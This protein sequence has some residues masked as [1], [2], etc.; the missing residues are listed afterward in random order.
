MSRIGGQHLHVDRRAL[1]RLDVTGPIDQ[2]LEQLVEFEAGYRFVREHYP[3][4]YRYLLGDFAPYIYRTDDFGKTWKPL[5]EP[6][7]AKGVRGYAHV[8]KEDTVDAR[9]LFLGT[10]FGLWVSVDGGMHW[11]QFKGGHMPAVAVRDLAIHPRDHD[12]V[13]ATHGRG[14]WI[15]DDITPLRK[16]DSNAMS[17]DAAFLSARPMQQRIE[18]NGGW[19]NGAAAFVG[20]NPSAGAVITYYQR[21]RHLFGK[22]K[23]EILDDQGRVIDT[24]PAGTRRGVNR[25]VWAMHLRPPHVPPAAQVTQAGTQGPRVLP[26]TYTVRMEKNGKIYQMDFSVGPDPRVTWSAGDR[27]SQFD[28]AMKV[29]ELFNDESTLFARIASLRQQ[30][31]DA[32]QRRRPGD[33][34]CSAAEAVVDEVFLDGGLAHAVPRSARRSA[35]WRH[36]IV[37]STTASVN[38]SSMMW[39]GVAFASCG[40]RR[41]LGY[42]LSR[43]YADR[44]VSWDH[45]K[46]PRVRPDETGS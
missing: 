39:V 33:A 35:Y 16:L 3:A 42:K 17:A 7:D 23:I 15:V 43:P 29:Y 19:V 14:I 8:I 46:L 41:A 25:V 26:G 21:T 13:I 44:V 28:A 1:R 40:A 38:R 22:L 4:I 27:Q 2:L 18:A 32:S 20:E 30:V 10:E 11:A 12:L 36:P 6:S 45:R 9:L 37:G 34:L 5:V 31:A 24:L